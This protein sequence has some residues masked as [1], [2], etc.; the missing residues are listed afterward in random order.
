LAEGK[1][2]RETICWP[3]TLFLVVLDQF[4]ACNDESPGHKE[5]S[6]NKNHFGGLSPPKIVSKK[7]KKISNQFITCVVKALGQKDPIKEKKNVF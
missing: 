5:A 1:G 6:M 4:Q 3:N 7:G 2:T